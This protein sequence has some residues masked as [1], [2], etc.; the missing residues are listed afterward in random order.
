MDLKFGYH[1]KIRILPKLGDIWILV[2]GVTRLFTTLEIE[3]A[4]APSPTRGITFSQHEVPVCSPL[5]CANM[6]C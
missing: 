1:F 5:P 6:S 3:A 2:L 4:S